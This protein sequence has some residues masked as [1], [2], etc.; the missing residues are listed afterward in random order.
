V[1]VDGFEMAVCNLSA[2]PIGTELATTRSSTF[3]RKVSFGFGRISPLIVSIA[4]K[5]SLS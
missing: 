1:S 5:L 4:G 3:I 2:T